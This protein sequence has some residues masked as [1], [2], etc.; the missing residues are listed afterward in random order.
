MEYDGLLEWWETPL[1]NQRFKYFSVTKG[2]WLNEKF[3]LHID[4]LPEESSEVGERWL[5][6]I[7]RSIWIRVVAGEFHDHGV[8]NL[9]R[10][11]GQFR[12]P[13]YRVI[14]SRYTPNYEHQLKQTGIAKENDTVQE[15]L[16]ASM[17]NQ[18]HILALDEPSFR[19]L[20]RVTH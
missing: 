17:D 15:Y 2:T 12:A 6:W 3:K 16:I 18:V 7:T 20:K 10:P 13:F 4:C 11:E 8:W 1:S 14:G 19:P 9:R 5:C